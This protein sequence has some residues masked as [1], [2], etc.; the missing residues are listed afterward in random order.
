MPLTSA[1]TANLAAR[2][3]KAMKDRQLSGAE[4]ARFTGIDPSRIS[5]ILRG[6][7]RTRNPNVMQICTFLGVPVWGDGTPDAVTRISASALKIWDGSAQD[8]DALI[9]LFDHIA[10]MR[11]RDRR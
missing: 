10:S 9:S 8:A 11:Q 5:R 6:E 4:V 1:E 2:I 3:H 7:F